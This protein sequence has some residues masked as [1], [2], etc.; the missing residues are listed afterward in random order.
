MSSP[1]HALGLLDYLIHEGVFKSPSSPMFLLSHPFPSLEFWFLLS[2]SNKSCIFTCFSVMTNPVHSLCH[3][4]L[5]KAMILSVARAIRNVFILSHFPV[6]AG[7]DS[8]HIYYN[9]DLL[10]HLLVQPK[11]DGEINPGEMMEQISLLLV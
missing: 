2:Y 1:G 6:L 11:L 3:C 10:M 4:I 5:S 7:V 9:T 8:C